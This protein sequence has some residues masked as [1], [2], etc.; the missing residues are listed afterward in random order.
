MERD[1]LEDN[2]NVWLLGNYLKLWKPCKLYLK[3][4]LLG[5]AGYP[6]EPWLL[7]PYR[8]PDIG[9]PQARFNDIHSRCRNTIERTN[10]VLKNRWRCL[11]SA[12][13][14]HYTPAKAIKIINVCAALHNICIHFKSDLNVPCEEVDIPE[15]ENTQSTEVGSTYLTAGQRIR[16]SITSSL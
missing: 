8:T 6:L 12:R 15:V 4:I 7:T 11:L 16:T 14:L 3:L 5:D 1:Y 9:S 2:R 10:G 13:E